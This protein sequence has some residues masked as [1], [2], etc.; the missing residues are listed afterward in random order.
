MT[1]FVLCTRDKDTKA[2]TFG[3]DLGPVSYLEVPDGISVPV[4][5][6]KT[7]LGLWIENIMN[8]A[9]P[10]GVKA[11]DELDIVFFVHGYN[12]DAEEALKRQRLVEQ[13]LRARGLK[14][15][16]IGFDWP[17]AG[18]A[19]AYLYD[20]S[21]AQQAAVYLIKGGIIPFAKYTA[22]KCPINVHVM[23]HSMGAFVVRE[24][25]R[26]VDKGRDAD[27]AN[28]WRIGQLVLFAGDISSS[29]FDKGSPEMMPVFDH[30]GRLT[31]YFSGYD[32]ALGVSN[33]KN[34]DISSRVG[35]VGMPI[36]NPGEA[37]ALDVDCGPRYMAIPDRK[38]KV[39]NGMVSHSWYLEDPVWYDDLAYTLAG[40][41]DRN[42]IP[43]RTKAGENDFV[44]KSAM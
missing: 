38:F 21:E 7:T 23:A 11:G 27:L 39:I 37:K 3:I 15:L 31:N 30:C 36:D 2:D 34:I 28:D 24:A 13:E 44:L 8:Q 14:C 42:A 33:V 1:S 19:G 10:E 17:T 6:Q 32:E 20:R 29:C 12:T 16:V 43:T 35:R 18:N 9:I 4:P 26:G 41:M 25:F 22:E 40:Q 5:S